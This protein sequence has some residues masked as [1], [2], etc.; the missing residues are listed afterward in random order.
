MFFKT[1]LLA[2]ILSLAFFGYAQTH[3][4]NLFEKTA[5]AQTAR[6]LHPSGSGGRLSH[7]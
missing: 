6:G 2:G 7:K 1:Y 4:M 3:G 5:G